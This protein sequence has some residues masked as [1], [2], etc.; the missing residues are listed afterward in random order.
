MTWVLDAPIVLLLVTLSSLL[1]ALMAGR[2]C[3]VRTDRWALTLGDWRWWGPRTLVALL[4]LV[5]TLTVV[6]LL[7]PE[8]QQFYPMWRP[9]RTA[10]DKLLIGN[11]GHSLDFIGWELLFRGTLLRTAMRRGDPVM[12]ICLQAIPFC[13]LH[14]DKPGVELIA[15]LFGGLVAGWFCLRARTFLPLWILHSAMISTVGTVAFLVR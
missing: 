2:A 6:V 13:L 7:S 10:W 8:L 12:A 11:L 3:G 9:A 4:V 5:P 14:M 1:L 15:S